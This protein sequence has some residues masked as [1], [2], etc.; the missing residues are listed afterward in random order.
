MDIRATAIPEVKVLTPRRFGDHRGYF[1]ETWS[2]PRM[3]AAGLDFAF[4]QDNES[5]SARAG[6][7]RGLHYQ[8]P[9]FAQA[10]LVRVAL[11]AI[12]DVAVDVRRG[13]PDLRPLGRRGDLG[14]ERRAAPRPAR[15]PARLRHADP[16]HARP[17]QGRQSLRCRQRRRRALERP[18]PRRRLGPARRGGRPVGQGPRPARLPRL[19]VALRVRSER[20]RVSRRP[21]RTG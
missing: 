21:G 6:T 5:L 14:G 12:R 16:E 17:L 20:M 2:A 19:G 15:L 11:G 9:P 10:K 13:S 1:C 18:R 8:A 7:L 3:A 4:V